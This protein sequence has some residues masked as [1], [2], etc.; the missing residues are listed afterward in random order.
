MKSGKGISVPNLGTFTFAPI[1]V[2]LAGTTNPAAR[3]K[4][5]RL[6][7]FLVVKDFARGIPLRQGIAGGAGAG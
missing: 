2:D 4:Q 6:P 1:S 5:E 7:V 3:D